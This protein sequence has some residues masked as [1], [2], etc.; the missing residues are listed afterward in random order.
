[1]DGLELAASVRKALSDD[2]PIRAK[3][4]ISLCQAVELACA[5][6]VGTNATRREYMRYYMRQYRATRRQRSDN[7][8][9][10]LAAKLGLSS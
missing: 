5:K 2:T 8:A 9:N 3:D 4:I 7:E 10:T 1:M 6:A